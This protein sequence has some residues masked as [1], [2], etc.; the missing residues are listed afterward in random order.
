MAEW[1]LIDVS[2]GTAMLR[3]PGEQYEGMV[4]TRP[5]RFLV[6]VSYRNQ[7][8]VCHLHDPGRLKEL[9]Y[10]G[11]RV[12]FREAVGSKTK[13]SITA[14]FHDGQWILTDTRFHNTIASKFLDPGC[15]REVR[16]GSHVIDFKCG[17]IFVEVKGG[18]LYEDG[19]A[20][21]PDAP[22]KRGS[23]H[24]RALLELKTRTDNAFLIVLFFNPEPI[25]FR[26]NRKTDPEFA[27]LFYTCLENNV[28]IKV[29]K[30]GLYGNEVVY[31]GEIGISRLQ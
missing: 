1:P 13:Y 28:R 8:V 31:R 16:Y 30:F 20:T 9:I 27:R 11:N 22:T 10:A 6:S 25:L 26:P 19:F 2:V 23:E 18:T 3:I 7:T 17:D 29:F 5:N 24:L 4:L 12:L 14:A 15:K 21:F